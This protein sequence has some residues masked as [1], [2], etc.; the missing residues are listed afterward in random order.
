MQDL[1]M[2]VTTFDEVHITVI[3]VDQLL[4]YK[5]AGNIPF[6]APHSPLY[7]ANIVQIGARYIKGGSGRI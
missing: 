5:Q 3:E 2:K 7:V 1:C 4:G 6:F